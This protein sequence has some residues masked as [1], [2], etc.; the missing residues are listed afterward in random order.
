MPKKLFLDLNQEDEGYWDVF[1]IMDL[2]T[3]RVLGR[4]DDDTKELQELKEAI[5][6]WQKA[7]PNIEVVRAIKWDLRE[8]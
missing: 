7:F 1:Y 8:G 5:A 6:F 2:D 3:R 4:I